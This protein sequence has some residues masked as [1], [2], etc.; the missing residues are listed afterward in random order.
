MISFQNDWTIFFR[1]PISGVLMALTII[2]LIVPLF[3][4]FRTVARK[5]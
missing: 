5:R 3:K 4:S 1:R 2:A